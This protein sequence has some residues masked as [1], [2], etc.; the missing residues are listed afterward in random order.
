MNDPGNSRQNLLVTHAVLT[1]LTPLVPIPFV[2]DQ[3][4]AYFMRSLVQHLATS[5]GRTLSGSDITSLAAHP[6]RGCALG[7]LGSVLLYPLK[8]VMRKVFFFLEWKRAV[9]TISHTYY[10]G[11]L[12]D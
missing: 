2:D 9:D 8:R 10:Q 4:Y 7:C 12:I 6:S 5:Q 1:G 11:Y 3:I